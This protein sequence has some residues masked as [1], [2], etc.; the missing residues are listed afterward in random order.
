MVLYGR[1]KDDSYILK[2]NQD[3]WGYI[4]SLK[5]FVICKTEQSS[6]FICKIDIFVNRALFTKH[7]RRV[8]NAL[9]ERDKERQE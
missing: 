7:G 6:C 1:K 4:L 3:R 8:Y 5:A 9:I 2:N